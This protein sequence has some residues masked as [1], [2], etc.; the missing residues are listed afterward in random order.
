M[1]GTL[2]QL[3][4]LVNQCQFDISRAI[5]ARMQTIITNARRDRHSTLEELGEEMQRKWAGHARLEII[6]PGGMPGKVLALLVVMPTD[7]DITTHQLTGELAQL[8]WW[9]LNNHLLGVAIADSAAEAA[10]QAVAAADRGNL[11]SL[12][13]TV[14]FERGAR[15]FRF[16]RRSPRGERYKPTGRE[17]TADRLR[18]LVA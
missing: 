5:L 9:Q 11:A 13:L 18:A 15:K 14:W 12:D 7:S 16:F 8:E 17:A 2:R 1:Q 4:H 6:Q 3:R 10:E